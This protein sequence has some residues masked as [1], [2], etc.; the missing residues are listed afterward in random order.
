MVSLLLGRSDGRG[1]LFGGG[2][3]EGGISTLEV[4][5]KEHPDLLRMLH[6]DDMRVRRLQST[7]GTR[8]DVSIPTSSGK[9]VGSANYLVT[10]SL[11]TPG[12]KLQLIMD[13]GSDVT[14]TQCSPC[15]TSC[16]NQTDAI[17]DPS[18]SSTY[19]NISC[20]S[21]ICTTI[22]SGLVLRHQND[23]AFHDNMHVLYTHLS[24]S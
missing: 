6:H 12:K 8:P 16:Y 1:A 20:S 7:N 18:K 17:F 15:V 3:G 4:V 22:F 14:W 13:T 21:S 2:G 9:S 10:V 19:A 24:F 5:H 23:Y 11:G